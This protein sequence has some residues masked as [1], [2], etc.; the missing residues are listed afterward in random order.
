MEVVSEAASELSRVLVDALEVDEHL[1]AR[2]TPVTAGLFHD[3]KANV[4]LTDLRR[5]SRTVL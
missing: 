2:D 4:F 5:S 1:R 3:V